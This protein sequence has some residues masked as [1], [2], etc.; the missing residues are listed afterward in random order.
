[1][2]QTWNHGGGQAAKRPPRT[3]REWSTAAVIAVAIAVAGCTPDRQSPLV[4]V[5]P[6]TEHPCDVDAVV[7]QLGD[8]YARRDYAHFARLLHDDFQ[9]I[10]HPNPQDPTQP[11]EWGRV[12]ELRIH[13]RMFEPQNIPPLDEPLPRD[14]WLASV[15]SALTAQSFEERP[16]FYR[17]VSNPDGLDPVRWKMWGA[18]YDTSVLFETRGE[19]NY[20]ISGQAW[21]VVAQDLAKPLGEPGRF[22]L[23]RWQDLGDRLGAGTAGVEPRT[24]STVKRL[25]S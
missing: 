7:T 20:Q 16:E 11:V 19:T 13:K 6:C 3:R 12:E 18:D 4:V 23:Y 17:S 15:T 25:Y 2:A 24:W 1:M 8:A 21:F 9:F 22:S 14:L 5:D 10:L